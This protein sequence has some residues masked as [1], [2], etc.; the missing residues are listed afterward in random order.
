MNSQSSS[1]ND[2]YSEHKEY[3]DKTC[4]GLKCNNSKTYLYQISF[5]I[6][7]SF[8]CNG[9]KIS[10]ERAGWTVERTGY[11]DNMEEEKESSNRKIEIKNDVTN[12]KRIN[13][14]NRISSINL[15]ELQ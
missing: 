5:T 7:S 10:I 11:A 1:N 15:L 4:A 8:L 6:G 13:Q 12:I 14:D 9:C 2:V 3:K